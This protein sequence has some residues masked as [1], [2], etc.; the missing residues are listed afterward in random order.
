MF[1][2]LSL[3]L[4]FRYTKAK[5]RNQF[6]S[7]I[8]LSSFIGIAIGVWAL[9][10]VL[11]VMNGFQA[12]IR[13]RILGMASH[14]TI[15][16]INGKLSDWPDVAK[17]VENEPDVIG[18]APYI[19]KEAMLTN[20]SNVHGALIRGIDPEE[21]KS[22][23]EVS[24]RM[25]QGS[26]EALNKKKY[27]IILGR[28]LARSIGATIGSKITMVTPSANVTPA[29]IMPRL[30]RFTVVGIFEVGH[31]QYDSN[32]ALINLRDA[33]VLFKMKALVTGVRLKFDNLYDAPRLS[34]ELE[35]KMS[36]YHRV[37]DWTQH[38]ANLFRAINIEKTMMM[39]ILS[40][41][42]AVAA[43]NIVSTLVIVVNDKQADIAILRT[44]G[45]SPG[46]IMR[47]FI[48]Q[49]MVIGVVGTFLGVVSGI[50]TAQNIDVI[51]PA[52]EKVLG[53]KFLAPDVY[54]ITDLPSEMKWSDVLITG[55]I[56]FC[57]TVLATIYPAWR[58]SRVQPAEA[59]RY[60]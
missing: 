53:M 29:G 56:S 42:I 8:T 44:L 38:H 22:V 19:L 10:T 6:I 43:F 32:M 39:I 25:R 49:G 48:S 41:I 60:E 12:E 51:V 36:G 16:S 1:K 59:L 40:L 23:S 26:Y 46:M 7:F 24:Q 9:I 27:S 31:N 47:I 2:P 11:S 58:A 54:L 37:I 33:Q 34:R 45:A 28:Y 57:L 52:L 20:A 18:S 4:G 14:A 17:L 21:E 15:S 3:F 30:K 35:K 55:T 5:R 50:L 13:D